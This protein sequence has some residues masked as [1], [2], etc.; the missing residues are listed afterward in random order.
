VW[1]LGEE[2]GQAGND[3]LRF[4]RVAID[5]SIFPRKRHGHAVADER[6]LYI[7]EVDV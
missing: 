1:T 4:A 2:L 5:E 6:D 7:G 3:L